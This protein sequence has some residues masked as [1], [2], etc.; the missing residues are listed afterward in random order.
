MKNVNDFREWID[1]LESEGELRRITAEV[2]WNE[3]LGAIT[4]M[5]LSAEGPAL[6]FENIKGYQDAECSK[7]L[8]AGFGNYNRVA[9]AI[10][11]PKGA[12]AKDM[13][14][15]FRQSARKR[16]APKVVETGPVK[17]NIV[18]G[19]DIDLFSLPVPKWH[20]WD[21]GRYID[22]FNTTVTKDPETGIHNLGMY[23]GMIC[24]KDRISKMLA[25]A[26]H[27]GQHYTKHQY[28]GTDMPVALVYGAEP[29]VPFL[30][31][32][33]LLHRGCSEYDII[34]GVKDSPI[35]L[36]KCETS[37]LL[38]PATAEIVIE[39]TMST[40]PS[41][42]EMEGPFAEHTGYYG[43]GRSRKPV[44]RV[45]CIT[46]R[47][48]PIFR[49]SMEGIR[50]GWPTENSF[51]ESVAMSAAAWNHLE[52]SGIP[53]VTDVW[54]N[55]VSTY[56]NIFVQIRKAYRGHAKQIA[57]AL[58]SM[59]GA[60]WSFKNVMVV[61]E[62]IDIRDYAQL[63]W[64]YAYRVNAG[65]NDLLFAPGNFGSLLDPSTNLEE[66]DAYKYGSGKWTR[67]LID[68]TRNWEHTRWEAWNNS[69]YPPV[70]VMTK[71]IE[72]AVK[73]RWDELGLG[74]IEYRPTMRIDLDE[75]IKERYSLAARPTEST[76]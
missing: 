36:V 49:G 64:A 16:V 10:G 1:L 29:L 47:D 56:L 41:T 3:E 58:W 74:D 57:N 66:R 71:E 21:G 12:P 5:V 51:T 2:D 70:I 9:L 65:E 55:P 15:H 54:V 18:R 40:D 17:E 27:W 13:I 31:L 61:E 33:P 39:G 52:D 11:M 28:S 53:G 22:T 63:D 48:K 43:G 75:S 42:Y 14:Q 45:S 62:D 44:V 67:V 59:S 20:D 50:P 60:Y 34:G 4:R 32:S 8:S 69:V 6:L 73:S 68:A 23:R 35:E 19:D 26:Q 76:S 25:F 7:V 38:V 46:H 30:A 37:D 72:G 24:D